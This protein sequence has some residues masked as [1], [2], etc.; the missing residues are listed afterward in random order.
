MQRPQHIIL[1]HQLPNPPLQNPNFI[2]FNPQLMICIQQ[3]P[4]QHFQL[5]LQKGNFTALSACSILFFLG[6]DCAEGVMIFPAW[7][8]VVVVVIVVSRIGVG[9]H[10]DGAGVCVD[11]GCFC[12]RLVLGCSEVGLGFMEAHC[13]IVSKELAFC[14]L[15][16][17]QRSCW[18]ILVVMVDV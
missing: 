11:C 4:I 5:A 18:L 12:G 6:Y 8:G 16:R 3:M 14:L 2:K 15:A 1:L 7:G 13:G 17:D 10:G 9:G